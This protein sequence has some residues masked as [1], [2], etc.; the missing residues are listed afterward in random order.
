VIGDWLKP[1]T[2]Q[3]AL[4]IRR[5]PVRQDH[6]RQEAGKRLFWGRAPLRKGRAKARHYVKS[7]RNRE[8]EKTATAGKPQQRKRSQKRRPS[9]QL[10]NK[11]E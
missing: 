9:K 2:D 7:E 3:E 1:R 8:G 11:E 10:F 4:A 6:G 5:K